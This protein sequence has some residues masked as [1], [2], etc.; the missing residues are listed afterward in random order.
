MEKE[1]ITVLHID[2][3]Q[4]WR[5][6]QQQVAYL[7]ERMHRC[8]FRTEVVCPPGS[9]LDHRCR[10]LRLPVHRITMFGELDLRA[11]LK[12]AA[13]TR[14]HSYRILHSHSAHAL[15]ITLLARLFNSGVRL[16]TTRRV[17]FH[18]RK[19]VVGSFKYSNG[20]LDKIICIS[21]RIKDILMDNGVPEDKL[22]VIHSGIDLDK[23]E[24]N[25]TGVSIKT[26]LGIPGNHLVIGTVAALAGHKDYPTL[27]NAARMIIDTHEN[28]TFLALGDGP[29]KAQL[30]ALKAEL[31]LGS[32]FLFAGFHENIGDYLNIFDVFTL[33]SREEGLGTS[34]LDAQLLGVPVAATRAGGIPELIIHGINGLLTEPENPAGLA[35]ILS[36]LID[37]EQLR[38]KL[39]REGKERVKRF[40]VNRMFEK[41]VQLYGKLI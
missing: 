32:R 6:G 31:K 23:F 39:A 35:D 2:T 27:L 4:G 11:A 21:R 5:G 3:V 19:P 36:R 38:R 40:D 22:I 17:D 29:E 8:G 34:L 10:T 12:I 14:K 13:Y 24:S 37:N 28:V 25:G 18:V 15:S 16:V 9:K 20:Y 33:P 1:Q 30:L 7:A 41:T 26:E